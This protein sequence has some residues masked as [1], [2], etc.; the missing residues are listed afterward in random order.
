MTTVRLKRAGQLTASVAGP[1]GQVRRTGRYERGLSVVSAFLW[2]VMFS[3][4]FSF[5]ILGYWSGD[6][7]EVMGI[8]GLI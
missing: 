1:S 7:G 2:G 3:L 4:S 5:D 6:M 8:Q